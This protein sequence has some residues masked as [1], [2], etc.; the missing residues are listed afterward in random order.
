MAVK[1]IEWKEANA[2]PV[3]IEG[4]QTAFMQLLA[5]ILVENQSHDERSS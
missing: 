3:K 4:D 1:L 2:V 5:V